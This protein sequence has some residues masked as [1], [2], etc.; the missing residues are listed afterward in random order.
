[1]VAAPCGAGKTL[2]AADLIA[3]RW[4]EGV[5][6]VAERVDQLHAMQALLLARD[7]PPDAIG[8][9]ALGTADQRALRQEQV[10][11]PIAL[12]THARMQL[13]A[14]QAYVCFPRHGGTATR[15]LMIVDESITPLLILSVPRLFIQGVLSQLGLRWEDLGKLDP[16]TI[17]HKLYALETLMTRHAHVALH[18]VGIRY[19]DWTKDQPPM[20][21]VVEV[22]R[23]AYYQMLYQILAGHYFSRAEDIDVL[24]PM[25][26][27]LTWY[28]CFAQILVL[29]AT[30]PLTDFLYP[31]YA[32][33]RPGTWNYHHITEAYKVS[34]DIGNLTKTAIV[35]HQEMFLGELKAHVLPILEEFQDPYIV[36]YKQLAADVQT[37]LQ[38]PIQHYGATRGS[39]MYRTT[40]SAVLLG[41]YRP[42]V[43]FDQL[44]QLLFGTRY[45]PVKMAVAHWIQ[46][47]YRTRI[48]SGEPIK[49]LVMGER[50][51]VRLFHETTQ[52]PFSTSVIGGADDPDLI[53][54][55]VGRMRYKVQKALLT[56]LLQDHVVNITAFAR[57]HTNYDK[58]KVL[59]AKD[60][61]LQQY[62]RFDGH[63][64]V[65][66]GTIRLIDKPAPRR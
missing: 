10:T 40:A 23:Y 14:P 62:Q 6:Y 29:D 24:V 46:E 65:Q 49:L 50:S 48:R 9:Y 33:L 38:R 22:R 42:P 60:G 52:I 63:L 17:D 53:E 7:V 35:T 21:R 3:E 54:K 36:T 45:S 30:A 26:P 39:N 64:D 20:K 5:L 2:A 43:V 4:R 16:D 25:V 55:I 12:L 19:Q 18:Q 27:H 11:K 41:A 34:S 66:D 59:R 32:I 31:D 58:D 15:R 44:A 28:Q 1:V 57:E 56:Q 51:A 8:L 37:V 47:C 61:I 13:D